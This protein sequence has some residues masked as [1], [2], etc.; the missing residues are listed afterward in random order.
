MA[1]VFGIDGILILFLVFLVPISLVLALWALIDAASRPDPDFQRA[2][3]NKTLW[4]VLPIVGLI[5]FGFVGGI[6]GLI[7][8]VAIRPSVKAQQ[9]VPAQLGAPP[10][11][12]WWLASD[13]RWYPPEAAR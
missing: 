9:I 12:G 5:F 11:P 6:L 10:P 8:L 2:G 7:Y 3:H 4:I 13:G 1:E